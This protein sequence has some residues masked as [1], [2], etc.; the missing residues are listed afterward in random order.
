M[1]D[2]GSTHNFITDK[3][4]NHLNLQLT[5]TKPFHVRVAD[6]HPIRCTGLYRRILTAVD[7]ISFH[8]D[9]YSLPLKGQD[10]VLGIQWLQQL[11]PTLCDWQ[12]Q[13]MEFSWAG[14]KQVVHGLQNT[15]ISQARSEEIHK[16]AK[17]GQ[18]CFAL[19][20]QTTYDAVS[21]VPDQMRPLLQKFTAIF[22]SPTQLPPP[23]EIE[24]RIILKE[25]SDPVNVCPYRYAHFQKEE[26]EHQVQ[27]MLNTGLV[28]PSSSPFSSPVL[29]VKKKDG[30]WR[31]CT[32][33]RALN[34]VTI[35][36]RFPIP[37]V[38]DML[39]ELHG[40]TIFT[41]LDLTAGYHQVRVHPA[42]THKTAF[43]THNGH[44]EYLVM[45]FGLCNVPSTFQALMNSVFRSY[46]RKLYS[47]SLMI[48]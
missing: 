13:T 7:G 21:S 25:G 36:D 1:I 44:Y 24:H 35:K 23:R 28:Q 10:I 26:I 4:A 18:A 47:F 19:T 42:D 11:G 32:D 29:L 2:S 48:S 46:L 45:P 12:A 22:A 43:R 9:Y 39:D 40:A 34:A 5:P 30:S 20:F 37:A 8:I 6:G 27:E 38:D 3:V 17:M 14:V 31:F 33:Y 16:E 41:K 15:R